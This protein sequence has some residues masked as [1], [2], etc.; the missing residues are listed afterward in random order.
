MNTPMNNETKT[1]KPMKKANRRYCMVAVMALTERFSRL[2]IAAYKDDG[3]LL[4]H[5]VS[6]ARP[7]TFDSK[8]AVLY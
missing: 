6:Y 2:I 4:I 3:K 7:I 5:H 8:M 1:V